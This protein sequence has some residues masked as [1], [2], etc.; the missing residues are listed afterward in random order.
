MNRTVL[1]DHP[2]L[3]T[4]LDGTSLIEASAGTGKTWTIVGLYLRLLLE[5]AVAPRS[6]L[7]VTFTNA[8]TAELKD[9]IRRELVALRDALEPASA[10]N[11]PASPLIEALVARVDPAEHAVASARIRL[12]VESLLDMRVRQVAR[13]VGVRNRDDDHFGEHKRAVHSSPQDLQERGHGVKVRVAVEEI[14]HRIALREVRGVP[15]RWRGV[16]QEL[17]RLLENA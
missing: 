2:V 4:P 10:S 7:V 5:R 15:V 16:D 14:Q 3:A 11:K 12:A 8:A 17:A 9:R 13:P 6:I 1:D